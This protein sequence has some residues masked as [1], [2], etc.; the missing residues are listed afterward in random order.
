MSLP[1]PKTY[2]P[3]EAQ[4]ARE[5]PVG[6][7]WQYEPKWDGFR[8]LAFRDGQRMTC[9][10]ESAKPL[11]RYFP[12]ATGSTIVNRARRLSRRPAPRD[13]PCTRWSLNLIASGVASLAVGRG[14]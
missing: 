8:C 9:S 6:E 2:A 11:T 4:P 3:M 12:D 7:Q 10:S 5:L 1:L 13:R 14:S